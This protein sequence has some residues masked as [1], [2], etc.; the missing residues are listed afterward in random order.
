MTPPLARLH[1]RPRTPGRS[2]AQASGRGD[3]LFRLVLRGHEV[4]HH[5]VGRLRVVHELE[6]LGLKLSD[7]RGLGAAVNEVIAHSRIEIFP[8]LDVPP[9]KATVAPVGMGMNASRS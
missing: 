7:D 4:P 5:E 6:A 1:A 9:P 2:P 8:T 3:L